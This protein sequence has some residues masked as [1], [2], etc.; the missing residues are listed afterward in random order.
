VSDSSIGEAPAAAAEE[1][2]PA[3][4]GAAELALVDISE[5]AVEVG[6]RRGGEVEAAQRG[7][8][9]RRRRWG[10]KG[11]AVS[12]DDSVQT[13]NRGQIVCCSRHVCA[14]I[15]TH[16]WLLVLAVS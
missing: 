9:E 16:R 10:G 15:N 3:A 5:S 14:L 12:S 2:A 11:V 6:E 4:A 1:A 13:A 7:E 8:A